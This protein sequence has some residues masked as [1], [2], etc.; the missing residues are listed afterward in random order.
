MR[1][2]VLFTTKQ[3]NVFAAAKKERGLQE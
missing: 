1:R 3:E 2:G